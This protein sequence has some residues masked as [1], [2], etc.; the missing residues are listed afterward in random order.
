MKK[1]LQTLADLNISRL[2]PIE[3]SNLFR[4]DFTDSSSILFKFFYALIVKMF[5]TIF[6]LD[7]CLKLS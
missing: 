4:E 7:L 6:S 2:S 1:L 3:I 5:Y